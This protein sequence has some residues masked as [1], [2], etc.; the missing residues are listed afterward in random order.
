M[1]TRASVMLAADAAAIGR[2]EANED[3]QHP[4]AIPKAIV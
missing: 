1:M 4:T 3:A 2:G